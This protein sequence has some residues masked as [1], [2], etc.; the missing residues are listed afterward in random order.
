MFSSPL[1]RSLLVLFSVSTALAEPLAIDLT[2]EVPA[3]TASPC[4][5]GTV[6]SPDGETITMDSRSFFLDGKPWIPISGEFHYSRY[7]QAEWRDELLKMKAGGINTVSTYVFWIHQEEEQGKFDW[8]G[9]LSL[10]DFLKLCQSLGLKAFVRMGPW[11]HGEVRNG[12]FPDWVQNSGTKLRTTDLAF[13][14]LVEPLFREEAKQMQGLLWKDGGPVIG[15][16]MDNECNNP[17]YLLALKKLA[18]ANGVDVPVYTMT[19]WNRARVPKAGLLPLFG[20]YSIG[21]WGGGLPTYRK[22]YFFTNVRDIGDLGAQFQNAHSSRNENFERFPY[23][24][25]EIGAGMM[26][27]YQRRV[28]VLPEDIGAMA[29][30]KLGCGNNLPGYYMYQGGTNPD[31]KLSWLNEDHPN[32]MPFKDYD[33]QTALGAC[34]Q[35]R[36]QFHILR[37]QH[38]FL[39]DF[40]PALARMPVYF[41]AQRPVDL[42]D[43]STLRWDV[44]S[45]GRAGFIFF[46]NHQPTVPL[47]PHP[48][49]QFALKTTGGPLLVPAQPVTIPTGTYGI[50]PVN[51]D[52]A[53]VTLAYATAQPLC[54]VATAGG[55]TV[56]FFTALEGIAPELAIQVAKGDQVSAASGTKTEADGVIYLRSLPAGTKAAASVVQANGQRVVFVVL[57][58]EEGRRLWRAPFAG[59]ERAILS[60]ATVLADAGSL[61]LQS[62]VAKDLALS[63]YPP[64]ASVKSGG[65]KI[66][67]SA[68]GIFSHFAPAGLSQP[69]APTVSVK[70][71]TPAGPLAT[72]LQGM[73]DATWKDAA[74]YQLKLPAALA[75][76]R[77]ILNLHYLGDCARLYVGDHLFDDHFFNGDPMPI[78]LWRIPAAQWPSLRLKVLPASDALLSR[79]PETAQAMVSAAKAAGTLDQ[80][81]VSVVDRLEARIEP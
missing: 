38:L 32:Q 33:F 76:R 71:E 2:T 49:V 61:R 68:D 63:V 73:D 58:P 34:G 43:F 17:A 45:D 14:K 16:Q 1:I 24:C 81:S 79:L 3:A 66:A 9:Q 13:M 67:A 46:A 8:S 48:G 56:Y 47:P 31:G 35:V 78:A 37:M 80:I 62:D 74:V 4:E 52:C 60:D 11:D 28:K 77:V 22:A 70:L 51:F 19:G 57:T 27:S 65:K 18:Q 75:K 20:S 64:L 25:V 30:V 26:S 42:M 69:V 21:F 44:R 50:W 7:P 15:V 5:P 39:E 53:G 54:R 6:K 40:G 29:L 36:E 41:P 72:S 59:K 12:G 23:A 10:R 55:E